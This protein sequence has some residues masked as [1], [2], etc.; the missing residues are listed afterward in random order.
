MEYINNHI[1]KIFNIVCIVMALITGIWHGGLKRKKDKRTTFKFFTEKA[2]EAI[3]LI[4][5]LFI[6]F[7]MLLN[8]FDWQLNIP[9]GIWVVGGV[10]V[11]ELVIN[12]FVALYGPLTGIGAKKRKK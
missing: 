1:D 9:K 4:T 3:T 2:Y 11:I 8:I 7:F 5:Y 6:A 10:G 12:K